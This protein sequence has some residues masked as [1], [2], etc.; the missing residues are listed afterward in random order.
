M[1]VPK[2][3]VSVDKATIATELMTTNLITVSARGSDGF[4]GPVT[5]DASV[6][7]GAGA[8]MAGWTVAW[9]SPTINVPLNGVA[10]SV[11]TL[12]I[13]SENKGLAGTMK[14]NASSSLGMQPA[15]AIS[16]IA[17]T[18]QVTFPMKLAN[19]QCTYPAGTQNIKVGTKVR[20]VNM[21]T[22]GNITI[23]M[24]RNVRDGL[25]HQDDPGTPPGQAYER[26]TAVN[27]D[28]Q[29]SDL[30]MP[31]YCHAP[32]PDKGGNNPK[33]LVVP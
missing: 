33:L 12:S 11:A 1:P 10:T 18:N 4:S 3:A 20:W 25:Q 19:G 23:H 16:A 26:V 29:L 17:A 24:D 9:S 7:D 14:I 5:L 32:G 15:V 6:V 31:W 8:A 2:L 30:P 21:E 22:T 13:P 28:G 27:D